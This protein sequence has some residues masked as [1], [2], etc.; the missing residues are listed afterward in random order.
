MRF[1]IVSNRKKPVDHLDSKK[2]N[3]FTNNRLTMTLDVIFFFR[4]FVEILFVN[5]IAIFL[6]IEKVKTWN[7]KEDLAASW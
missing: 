7:V 1:F 6:H 3:F 4:F 2:A 5:T